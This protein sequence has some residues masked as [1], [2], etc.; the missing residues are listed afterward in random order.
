MLTLTN[1]G[2]GEVRVR[3]FDGAG[4]AVADRI[5]DGRRIT[6]PS[7]CRGLY[8]VTLRAPNGAR[9]GRMRLIAF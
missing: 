6:M 2:A 9:V 4:R 8:F 1:P 5:F 7:P 3:I